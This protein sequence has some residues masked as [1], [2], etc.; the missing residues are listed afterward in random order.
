M[1]LFCSKTC[2]WPPLTYASKYKLFNSP[3]LPDIP[4]ANAYFSSK[5]HSHQGTILTPGKDSMSTHQYRMKSQQ[6]VH[7]T[8]EQKAGSWWDTGWAFSN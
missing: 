2:E 1:L 8:D 3:K 5:S 4:I 6:W 7:L